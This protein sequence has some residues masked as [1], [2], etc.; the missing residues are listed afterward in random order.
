M[1]IKRI[2]GYNVRGFREMKGLTQS[3]LAD[4]SG[5]HQ[6]YIGGVERG[7]RNVTIENLA[8]L[9]IALKVDPNILLIPKSSD[10]VSK[11]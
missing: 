11:S 8:R 4:Q 7:E 1:D 9:A 10:W 5:I 2:V 3:E 6:N